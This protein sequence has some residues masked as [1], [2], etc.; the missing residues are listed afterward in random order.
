MSEV[1]TEEIGEAVYA[2][3]TEVVRQM[4]RDLSLTSVATLSTLARRGPRRVTELAASEGVAQPSMTALV[5]S[6]ERDGLVE[7]R[8]DPRDR[9]AALVTVTE[10]GREYVA[11]RRRIGTDLVSSTLAELSDED[12]AAL[13]DA[14]GALRRVREIRAAHREDTTT[15]TG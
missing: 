14:V 4:P 3:A 13:A 2:L 7:R 12:R 11:H 10:A 6:L 15:A 8:P 9:R 1:L 5:T